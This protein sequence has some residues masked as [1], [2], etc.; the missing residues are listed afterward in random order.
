MEKSKLK[1]YVVSLRDCT[2]GAPKDKKTGK[3]FIREYVVRCNPSLVW[4]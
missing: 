1:G 4:K 3:G 2:S